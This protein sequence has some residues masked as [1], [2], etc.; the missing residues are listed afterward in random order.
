MLVTQ[1][2][3]P[4]DL[5]SRGDPPGVLAPQAAKIL[6]KFFYGARFA[7]WDLLKV[8]T[9]LATIIT[10]WT[11]SCDSDLFRLA[12]YVHGTVDW[13]L[14]GYVGDSPA[15]LRI[16]LF[17]DA[18]F[19]GDRPSYKSTSRGLLCLHGP[20]TYMPIA[21][22]SKK[23]TSVSHSTPKAEII[24]LDFGMRTLALPALYI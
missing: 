14:I 16:R 3:D 6:M 11:T 20:M 4:L 13:V 23:Q 19:A 12:R 17:P 2:D 21:A 24:S 7:R 10:K 15:D 5:S 22:M 18:D 1:S 8:I 9:T